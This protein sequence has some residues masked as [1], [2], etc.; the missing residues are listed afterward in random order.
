MCFD[1]TSHV[2]IEYARSSSCFPCCFKDK[3]WI[4]CLSLNP[5]P[6]SQYFLQN[7]NSLFPYVDTSADIIKIGEI[8]TNILY[9][10]V[11]ALNSR[12]TSDL[13]Q[14]ILDLKGKVIVDTDLHKLSDQIH[15]LTEAIDRISLENR[16]L[17]SELV[18]TKNVNSRLQQRIMNL[19]QNQAKGE[20][21]SRRNNVELS[22]IPNS[23]CDEGLENN[24]IN[25]CKES[26]IDVDAR[27]IEG[28]HWLL[29]SRNSR[30]LDKRV[31]VKFGNRKYAEA[32][33]KD[34]KR[35]SG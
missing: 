19:E 17:T 9:L 15:K 30:G 6:L 13:V 33:L 32:M 10:S 2:D 7:L 31:I 14:K 35:I 3:P 18:I 11:S 27:D 21:Y 23:I 29:L 8:S 5:N 26:G 16:K 34:K 1:F 20:Q 12:K 22:G 25:I 4:W 28:C 24:V